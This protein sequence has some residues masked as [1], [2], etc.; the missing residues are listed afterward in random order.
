MFGSSFACVN[1]SS[2]KGVR[3]ACGECVREDERGVARSSWRATASQ[4]TL[5]AK[6]AVRDSL[7]KEKVNMTYNQDGAMRVPLCA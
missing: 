2:E 3:V 5:P 6:A 7:A 1:G 4:P